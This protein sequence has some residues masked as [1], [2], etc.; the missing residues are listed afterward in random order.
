MTCVDG[1][2]NIAK[3]VIIGSA[4]LTAFVL[5]A[6]SSG[7]FKVGAKALFK[8]QIKSAWKDLKGDFVD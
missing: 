5:S 8:K 7:S 6:G 3:D 4:E 2:A 1:V